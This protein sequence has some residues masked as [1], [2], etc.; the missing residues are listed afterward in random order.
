MATTRIALLFLPNAL[1][2]A[3]LAI[4]GTKLEARGGYR[5]GVAGKACDVNAVFGL[6]FAL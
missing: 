5:N 1:V 4:A 3:R 2:L 6:A